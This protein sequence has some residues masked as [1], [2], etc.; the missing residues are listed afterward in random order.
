MMQ[1]GAETFLETGVVVTKVLVYVIAGVVSNVVMEVL[2]FSRG[3]PSHRVTGWGFAKNVSVQAD[4][5][6]VNQ[7]LVVLVVKVEFETNVCP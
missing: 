4:R 6:T 5:V 1:V 3:Y 7:T 2:P